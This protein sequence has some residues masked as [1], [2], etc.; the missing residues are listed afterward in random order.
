[1]SRLSAQCRVAFPGFALDVDLDVPL[2]GITAVFGA[3]GSGKS[4]L[5]RAVA[6]LETQSRGH[7]RIDDVVWQ[8]DAKGVFLPPHRR[9]VG[10]VF[11]DSRLFPHLTVERNLRYGF[12][13]HAPETRY[14]DID[15][16]IEVMDMLPLLH[17]RPASLSGGEIQRVAIARAVLANPR[18]LLMDEPLASLDA[19]RKHGILPFIERLRDD[20][21]IPVVYVSHAMEEIIRLADTLVL[22]SE[23]KVAA[24]GG[25]EELTGRLDLHPLTGRHEAG[26][27]IAAVTGERDEMFDLTELRFGDNRLLVAGLDVP[28]GQPLRARI[29]ARDVALSLEKPEGTSI[30]NLFAGTVVE[31]RED[32]GPQVDVLLDIGVP[33]IARIT[34]K[35]CSDLDLAPGKPIHAMVKAVAVDRH[36]MGRHGGPRG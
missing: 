22:L 23:G 36:S 17:R 1:M 6:G 18:L 3:S 34:R 21:G 2:S 26:A 29:R 13:R 12:K 5:L 35:S 19:R 27:V 25:V 11:Q 28:V 30:L 16:V 15:R 7:V 33:L 9:G 20:L 4:T 32:K 14:V 10:Y 31:I 24:T 8:D